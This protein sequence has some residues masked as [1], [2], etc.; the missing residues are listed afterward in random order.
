M[1]KVGGWL[2]PLISVECGSNE[3]DD[4]ICVPNDE[5][6]STVG[7]VEGC[8]EQLQERVELNARSSIAA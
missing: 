8:L 1:L 7:A 2:M 6:V 4:A 5:V 3:L